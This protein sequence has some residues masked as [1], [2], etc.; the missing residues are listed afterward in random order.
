MQDKLL[1]YIAA[2]LKRY[3]LDFYRRPF[4]SLPPDAPVFVCL[5]NRARGHRLTDDGIALICKKHLGTS[6]V[7]ATRHTFAHTMEEAGALVSTIQARLGHAS[8]ETTGRYL[9]ALDSAENPYARKVAA[10]LGLDKE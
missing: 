1:P 8:L 7:H 2:A 5:G 3:L 10:L 6:K 9:A 4:T